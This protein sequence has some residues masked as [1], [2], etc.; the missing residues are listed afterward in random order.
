MAYVKAYRHKHG[1]SISFPISLEDSI[2]AYP[3]LKAVENVEGELALYSLK[4]FTPRDHFDPYDNIKEIRGKEH[5]HRWQLEDYWMNIQDDVEVQEKMY[6]RL[7]LNFIKKCKLFNVADQVQDSGKYLQSAYAKKSKE[8]HINWVDLEVTNLKELMKQVLEYTR[9][10]ID[11]QHQKLK[12]HNITMTFHSEAST[13]G[14]ASQSSHS[15]GSKRKDNRGEKEPSRKKHKSN[16]SHP[17]STSS[18]REEELNRDERHEEQRIDKELSQEVNESM[19]STVQN[20]KGKEKSSQEQ[21]DLTPHIQEIDEDEEEDND[22]TTSPP[23]EEQM[24]EETQVEEGRSSIPEWLKERLAREVIA[25]DEEPTYDLESL[26]SQTQKV[27][28]KKKATKMSKVIRDD[29]SS[30]KLQIAIPM[31]DKYE[32]EIIADEYDMET[33]D[34]GPLTSE[35]AIGDANDSLKT[36]NDMLRTEVKKNKRLEKE[37]SVWRFQQFQEPLRQQN[38]AAAPPPLLPLESVDHMEKMRNST[39]LMDT[40]IEDSYTKVSKFMKGTMKT[41]DTVIKVLGRTHILIEAFEA[42]AYTIDVIIPILQVTRR[43]PR[44]VLT[45]EKIR[46]EGSTP[47]FLHW[48]SL[49]RTKK[50][51]FE[52]IGNE[53]NQVQDDMHLIHDKIV[54]VAQ[55]IL[56]RKI[57]PGMIIE[58]KELEER[59]KVIFHGTDGMIIK[60]QLDDMLAL[61][62]LAS[63]TQELEPEWENAIVK[64]FEEVMHMEEQLKIL[65]KVPMT[66]IESITTKFIEY[67]KR[68]REK[69]N[70]ILEES[71]L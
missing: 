19:E 36:V 26:L 70:K 47:N 57:D 40:C 15:R 51:V 39:Q 7:P 13:S 65:P 3:F 1:T 66:K 53:C 29:S 46:R 43:T 14:S 25:V 2:E 44:E 69:G 35:Q 41:L 38:P 32:D 59:I 64:A 12:E 49:L 31:V 6:S 17:S 61:V 28:E 22:E 5:G 42:F 45:K 62:V 34:L 9:I 50:I 23:R 60:R 11:I 67:A 33:I 27:T 18:R 52:A 8:I 30:W 63:K 58:A 54:E 55:I 37:I 21:K 24:L 4:L 48:S 10:Q 68:K 16:F 56:E 71:L 20:D